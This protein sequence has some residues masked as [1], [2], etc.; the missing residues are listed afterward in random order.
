MTLYL[1]FHKLPK[2]RGRS[3]DVWTIK[4]KTSGVHLG[5]V[6][7]HPPFREYGFFPRA[8]TVWGQSC[9]KQL[10]AFIEQEMEARG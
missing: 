5:Q 7:W 8:G 4:G 3:T 6:K 2:E 1:T 10:E 9:R